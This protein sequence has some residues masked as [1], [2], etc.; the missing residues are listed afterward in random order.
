V[1][2]TSN[3]TAN[4]VT[5]GD[6]VTINISTGPAQNTNSAPPDQI[7]TSNGFTAI[8]VPAGFVIQGVIIK[9]PA[10]S[11]ITKTLKGITGDSASITWNTGGVAMLPINSAAVLGLLCNGVETIELYWY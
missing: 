3:A 7:T 11:I 10:G 5:V 8:P 1:S 2:K 4:V 6:G 9:P